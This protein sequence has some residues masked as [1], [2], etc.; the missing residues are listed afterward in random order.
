MSKQQALEVWREWG[1]AEAAQPQAQAQTQ[2]LA[3]GSLAAVHWLTALTRF[4]ESSEGAQAKAGLTELL[5]CGSKSRD[6][7]VACLNQARQGIGMVF[8]QA[9][10][11]RRR[12]LA[13]PTTRP[14]AAAA[15]QRSSGERLLLLPHLPLIPAC[16]PAP[17]AAGRGTPMPR[18][19]S[20][21]QHPAPTA[22]RARGPASICLVGGADSMH[23]HT[24]EPRLQRRAGRCGGRRR[25]CPC[26]PTPPRRSLACCRPSPSLLLC[27]LPAPPQNG[28]STACCWTPCGAQRRRWRRRQGTAGTAMAR[29]RHP[30]SRVAARAVAGC[31]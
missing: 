16:P 28:C 9:G 5:R 10:F 14:P 6:K 13:A 26:L 15:D 3:L 25:P 4:C 30:W 27:S 20:T 24:P 21:A 17:L 8:R 2:P 23:R 31:S 11:E 12:R 7:V 1:L 29:A 19:A 18:L 22:P